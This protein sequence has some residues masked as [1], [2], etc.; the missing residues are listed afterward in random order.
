MVSKILMASRYKFDDERVTK[1]DA[2]EALEEQYGSKEV[3]LCSQFFLFK[4]DPYVSIA[5]ISFFS[6]CCRQTLVSMI[7]KSAQ[8]LTCWYTYVKVR[9]RK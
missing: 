5:Y 7:I 9:R 1:V 8:M 2:K 6:S 3:F 4:V